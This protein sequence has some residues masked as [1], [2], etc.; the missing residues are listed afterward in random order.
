MK[1]SL[2]HETSSFYV[3]GGTLRRDAPSYVER[4]ADQQLYSA[5]CHHEVCYVLTPRQLGKSSLMV[6]T[7][8]KLREAGAA[9]VVLDLTALGQNLTAE[10]WYNGLLDKLG[11]QLH[12]EDEI[13]ELGARWEHLGPLQ[14]WVSI[15][16]QVVLPNCYGDIV[17]FVDEIDSVRSLPFS[18]D[19]FFAG[20]RELYNRR[21]VEPD[22][23]RLTFCLLGV[24]TPSDLVR[25]T[26][27]T[28]FNIG[29]RV[30]LADFSEDEAAPLGQGF[31]VEEGKS[32]ALLKRVLYWTGGHPYLTQRLCRSVAE[33]EHLQSSKDVDRI[34]HRLFLSR[35]ARLRDDNLLFVK[36]RM[37]RSEVETASLLSLYA[38]IRLN[39][40]VRD[41]EISPLVSVLRLSGITK[42][43]EGFLRIRNRVYY[44][45]FDD[46]WIISNLP[47]AELRRQRAAYLKGLKR[48]GVL[49]LAVLVLVVSIGWVF[50]YQ[51]E[52]AINLTLKL[53]Q[54]KVPVFWQ[55]AY[56]RG[57]PEAQLGTLLIRTDLPN[58]IVFINEQEYGRTTK[59]GDLRIRGLNPGTYK[60]RAEKQGFQ[61]LSQ[62]AKIL[63]D[64]E[65]QLPFKLQVQTVSGQIA[66]RNSP[67]GTSVSLDSRYVGSTT[68]NGD[69][70]ITAA[71]G[72]HTIDLAKE[73]YVS[74]QS[75]GQLSLGKLLVIDGSL[76]VDL[77]AQEW[78]TVSSSEDATRIRSFLQR[79]PQ[80]RFSNAA[81]GRV[82]QLTWNSIKDSDD[83]QQFDAF[84]QNFPRSRFENSA[85]EKMTHL[86]KEQSDWY[87][88]HASRDQS[89]LERFLANYPAGRYAH[90]AREEI[91][92]LKDQQTILNVL[93]LY[94]QSYNKQDM[95]TLTEIWPTMPAQVRRTTQAKFNEAESVKLVLQL[96]NGQPQL[97]GDRA[98]VRGKRLVAW[99]KKDKSTSNDE[100]PF[101]F[102]LVREG[103]HWVIS[104]G[105]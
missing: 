100:Y 33:N 88:A 93:K 52:L 24:A 1:S 78:T 95:R 47:G 41:D 38:K 91:A 40:R 5:L 53:P 68:D 65:T 55:S 48:A 81:N 9:V 16:R 42:V 82:E 37:L 46:G 99:I 11:Q 76:A 98:T 64:S 45:V 12:L 32:R 56:M 59:I 92:Q 4:R 102:E 74:K 29:C 50:L 85:R 8:G 89:S 84:L 63:Q 21:T 25:D 97:N 77:E 17:I 7:A 2:R 36:E 14:R 51:R 20:I 86:L 103:T 10:Q 73:G 26:R 39:K 28:P 58:V 22:L 60:I 66:I 18:V 80:G 31:G 79:Y 61:S 75:G 90:Q 13:D 6:R 69:L 57:S 104:K 101:A 96:D 35:S 49:F 62:E 105:Q 94:E 3:V 43:D 67:P 23:Q 70:V 27:T 34:C 72:E 87:T 54:P 44:E 30:E 71:P 83:L 15:L 19:E